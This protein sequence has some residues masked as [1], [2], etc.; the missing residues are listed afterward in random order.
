MILELKMAPHK[1]QMECLN[2]WILNGC[3]GIVKAA[4][5]TG[6]S[7][8]ALMAM[9]YL[10]R[11]CASAKFAIIVPTKTLQVQARETDIGC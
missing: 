1:W 4:T 7:L 8:V 11:K 9:E 2:A 10:W 6:K 5:G 3:H